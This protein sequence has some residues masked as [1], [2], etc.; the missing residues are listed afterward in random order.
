VRF[1]TDMLGSA[2]TAGRIALGHARKL[3]D[4]DGATVGD[5]LIRIGFDG[6][7]HERRPVPH[8][9]IECHIEQGPVLAEAGADT[10]IVEGVQSISWQRLTIRGEAA[11]AGTTPI[12]ARHDAALAAA[13]VVVEARRMCDSG[14]FGQLRA[15]AN[16]TDVLANAVLRLAGWV[17]R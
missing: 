13:C 3:T 12:E 16:G 17:S 4:P 10:G 5:E 1:G 9:C 6:D 14:E 11:H 8:A 7:A 2:V 15:T